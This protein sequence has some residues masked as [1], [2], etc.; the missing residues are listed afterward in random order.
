MSNGAPD[1]GLYGPQSITWRV[2]ADPVML[3]AGLRALLLQAVHPVA[4]AGVLEH[5]DFRGDAWGRLLR[6]AEYVGVTSYGT[7][8]DAERAGARVRAIHG[9]LSAHDPANGRELRVDEPE[10][11]RW[12]HCC[13][14]DSFLQT[15]RRCGGPLD[16]GEADRYLA[17][18]AAGARLVGLDPA[19][20]PV[21]RA[22]LDDYFLAMQPQLAVGR[23]ARST[24][25]FVFR[26]P[27]PSWLAVATPARPA[28]AAT[29]A[30]AFA[31]LPRWARRLYRA[32]GMPIT[33]RLATL[34]GRALR[35]AL[36]ALPPTVREG[37]HYKA[38]KSRLAQPQHAAR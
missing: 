24:A 2:H 11:L 30:L 20:V 23:A 35:A 15:Y 27:M 10:L 7:V 25:F 28:W 13:E 4:L 5:S 36:L 9:R 26:P 19:T 34:H 33:D 22:Q 8:A 6:T 17:E 32:P 1:V 37:P 38:A 21:S 12:V 3:L 18:Q 31:L 14:V 16:D 29:A